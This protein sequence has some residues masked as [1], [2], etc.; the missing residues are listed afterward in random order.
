[1]K[2]K[3]YP[4]EDVKLINSYLTIDLTTDL[5]SAVTGPE[6]GEP[7]HGGYVTTLQEGFNEEMYVTI[8]DEKLKDLGW[9]ADDEIEISLTENLLDF[10]EVQSIVLRNLTKEKAD[11]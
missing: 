6:R 2:N 5:T 4:D 3:L 9:N 10:G 11:E 8:P 1:M 7:E